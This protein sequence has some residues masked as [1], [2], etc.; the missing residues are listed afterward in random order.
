MIKLIAPAPPGSVLALPGETV[1]V[2]A[3]GTVEIKDADLANRL[4]AAGF[5][6]VRSARS[7]DST[8]KAEP[9][10]EEPKAEEPKAEEPKKEE[11]KSEN[12]R[13]RNR[14]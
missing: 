10:K 13:S 12:R 7:A 6:A 4:K 1:T 8:A 2:G 9:K 14:R 11:P 3:D 5:K